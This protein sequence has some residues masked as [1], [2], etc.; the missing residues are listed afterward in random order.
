M[1]KE[2]RSKNKTIYMMVTADK[3]ELPIAISDTLAGLA[4]DTGHKLDEIYAKHKNWKKGH[5]PR[6]YGIVSVIY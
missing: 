6:S 1:T 3:Y 2:F 5:K 4:R